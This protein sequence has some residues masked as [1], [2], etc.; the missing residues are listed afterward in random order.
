MST[1]TWSKSK[2]PNYL[3]LSVSNKQ[4]SKENKKRN[5]PPSLASASA[6][7]KSRKQRIKNYEQLNNEAKNHPLFHYW[8][9]TSKTN[10]PWYLP[11]RKVVY[12]QILFNST[13]HTKNAT[14][15]GTLLFQIPFHREIF[16]LACLK[17]L[18]S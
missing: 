11:F 6:P 1:S 16:M 5:Q 12:G 3:F 17:H 10:W 2:Q 4:T 18:H 14:F 7:Q 13:F 9:C 8:S 15:L